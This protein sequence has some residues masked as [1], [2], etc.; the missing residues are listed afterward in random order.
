MSK[1]EELPEGTIVPAGGYLIVRADDFTGWTNGE[2]HVNLGFSSKGE[3]AALAIA[4]GEIVDSFELGP[5]YTDVSFGRDPSDLEKLVYFRTPTPGAVNGNDGVENGDCFNISINEL[6]AE[7][8]E[9]TMPDQPMV[10][11]D[12][13]ALYSNV[14]C[15]TG[16]TFLGWTDDKCELAEV[17]YYDGVVVSNL[18]DE[19]GGEYDLYAVWTA[20]KAGE[21]VVKFTKNGAETQRRVIT[22]RAEKVSIGCEG[23][24]AGPL[25]AGVGTAGGIDI[26]I[27]NP[28]GTKSISVTKL[29]T[30]MKYDS[31]SGKIT[32]VSA[33]RSS[34]SNR[35]GGRWQGGVAYIAT[36]R[37][38]LIQ[39]AHLQPKQMR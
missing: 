36:L 35:P 28:G 18:T 22:V 17:M 4:E 34:W 33:R 32:G 31:K 38:I 15:R 10:Y 39:Y 19:A 24:S 20:K 7:S 12:E 5:Q 30:G 21:F 25:P 3:V 26:Q 6:M 16:Y 14:F 1:W 9:G 23:L 8:G 29:P 13:E 27:G 37:L 11:D 2:V